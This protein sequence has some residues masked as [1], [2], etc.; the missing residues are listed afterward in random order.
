MKQNAATTHRSSKIETGMSKVTVM[1]C[2][3]CGAVEENPYPPY[4]PITISA[5]ER[6]EEGWT[7]RRGHFCD[8][9]APSVLQ[10]L[11][12]PAMK[13]PLVDGIRGTA[14]LA[15]D[16]EFNELPDSWY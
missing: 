5:G 3:S 2:D 9:C 4:I 13:V 10:A 12:G 14:F 11:D 8:E 7:L 16:E 6:G 15:D 1:K